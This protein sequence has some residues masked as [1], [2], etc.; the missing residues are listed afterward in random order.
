MEISDLFYN[1]TARCFDKSTVNSTYIILN[2]DHYPFSVLW[3][4]YFL[5]S[6]VLFIA[7]SKEFISNVSDFL[8]RYG[9]TNAFI[10]FSFFFI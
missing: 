3:I 10:T 5:I 7:R 6:Q 1:N 9:A 2:K 8:V 4:L